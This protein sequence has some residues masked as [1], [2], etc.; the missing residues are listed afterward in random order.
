MT[1]ALVSIITTFNINLGC[2][3]T[4]LLN[5]INQINFLVRLI[6]LYYSDYLSINNIFQSENI[7]KDDYTELKF[8]SVASFLI[9]L[10][11]IF[12]DSF[13]F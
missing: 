11:F 5:L 3:V 12:I 4:F 8:Y 6:V 13:R 1:T 10:F 9:I 7:L 2:Q